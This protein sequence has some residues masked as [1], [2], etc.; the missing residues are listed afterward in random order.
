M[1]MI[2]WEF[3][4]KSFSA[5]DLNMKL[6]EHDLPPTAKSDTATRTFRQSWRKFSS[7]HTEKFQA[8]ML[9]DHEVAI[10]QRDT[11]NKKLKLA[12]L[13]TIQINEHSKGSVSFYYTCLSCGH[14][15]SILSQVFTHCKQCDADIPPS[16]QE[17][18]EVFRH[19]LNSMSPEGRSHF[20]VHYTKDLLKTVPFMSA[21]R[22]Y[23]FMEQFKDS[24]YSFANAI[25][26]L[27][28][29]CYILDLKN[30]EDAGKIVRAGIAAEIAELKKRYEKLTTNSEVIRNR[31]LDQIR[32]ARGKIELYKEVLGD[33]ASEL[34]SL[35]ENFR[36]L[37]VQDLQIQ[38][39]PP[40]ADL[41]APDSDPSECPASSAETHL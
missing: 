18:S 26:A 38:T 11:E 14:A 16:V 9:N 24:A 23:I 32:E 21:G 1:Y 27:G 29:K 36:E 28:D 31:R 13:G 5:D 17:I 15:N 7:V 30:N 34:N 37:V 39:L 3:D 8:H 20:Y 4:K 10:V 33:Y 19:K 41:P 40:S 25:N 12:H 6:S 35:A 2:M 22:P